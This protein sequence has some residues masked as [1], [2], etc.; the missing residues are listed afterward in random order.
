VIGR[1]KVIVPNQWLG[2]YFA[3]AILSGDPAYTRNEVR[4]EYDW[5]Y[6]APP[7]LPANGFSVRWS[8]YWGFEVGTY[9]FFVSSDDG[10][11]LWLDGVLLIDG[12]TEGAADRQA[13]VQVATEGQHEV[14]LE[15]FEES[16]LARVSLHWRR[17]DLYPQWQADLYREPWVESG[18]AGR[19]KDLAIQFDWGDGAPVG[20]PPDGFSIAWGAEQMFEPGSQRIHIYADDGFQLFLDGNKIGEEGWYDGQSGGRED[21]YYDFDVPGIE[22]H[23][24]TYNFHDRGSLAEARL[25]IEYLEHPYWT[26]EYF[27]NMDLGGSPVLVKQEASIFYDWSFDKPYAKLP[28]SDHFSVRWSGQRYFHAGFYRFGLFADDGVRLRVDGE[29]LVDAWHDARATYLTSLMYLE[30]GYHDVVVEYYEN[31]GEAEIRFWYQ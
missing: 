10:V 4:I 26:A 22:Y 31:T 6:G 29:L 30:T 5:A 9:T 2:E 14:R 21:V 1:P 11:R 16:D 23:D 7:G 28:S 25:W 13:K 8:G 19:S 12:W 3:N 24:I 17:T 18:W 27:G 15:Y 20:L